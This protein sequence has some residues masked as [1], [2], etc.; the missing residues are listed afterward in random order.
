MTLPPSLSKPFVSP[1]A[2]KALTPPTILIPKAT[3]KDPIL[4][5]VRSA[6]INLG[7][8]GVEID[9]LLKNMNSAEGE[10][11]LIRKALSHFK[12]NTK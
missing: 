10:D 5:T 6:L 1:P 3:G 7:Y 8:I 11:T 9:P 2:L 4:Q 12:I